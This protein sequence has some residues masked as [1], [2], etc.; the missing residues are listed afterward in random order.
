[1]PR[2]DQTFVP[3]F[4]KTLAAGWT[5]E[6]LSVETELKVSFAGR[7][8]DMTRSIDVNDRDLGASVFFYL[9]DRDERRGHG[10][11][12]LPSGAEAEALNAISDQ[13]AKLGYR[14]GWDTRDGLGL[15][16]HFHKDVRNFPALRREFLVLKSLRISGAKSG[17]A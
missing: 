3:L 10:E 13:L 4:L 2:I 5:C 15:S 8:W 9:Q 11:T 6:E 17:R 16:G 12:R 7:S 14:G 1:M